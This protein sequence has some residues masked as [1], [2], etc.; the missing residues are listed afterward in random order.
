VAR[1]KKRDICQPLSDLAVQLIKQAIES[2]DQQFIFQSSVADQP[3]DRRAMAVALRGERRKDGTVKRIGI[4]EALGLK[5]FT[6]HDLR[7]TSASMARRCGF[8]TAR[9]APCLDHQV[10]RDDKG[11]L[12]PAVT[13][14]HYIHAEDQDMAEKR[15]VLDAVAKELLRIIGQPALETETRLAA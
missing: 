10:T 5:P 9:I 15:E 13:D 6:A 11:F 8:S 1:K 4:C 14:L 2:E 12:I 7:R 3:M